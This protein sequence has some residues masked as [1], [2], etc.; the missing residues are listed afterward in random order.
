MLYSYF[1]RI[2]LGYVYLFFN[3]TYAKAFSLIYYVANTTNPSYYWVTSWNSSLP[4]SY[5][6]DGAAYQGCDINSLVGAGTPQPA[7]CTCEITGLR[8]STY[9]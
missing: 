3:L 1:N 8:E 2:F 4:F 7:T 6:T 9:F 5:N